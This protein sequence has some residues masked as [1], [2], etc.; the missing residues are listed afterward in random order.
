MNALWDKMKAEFDKQKASIDAVNETVHTTISTTIEAQLLP[1]LQE[2]DKL[3]AEN[4][5]LKSRIKILEAESR[6]N[7]VIIHGVEEKEVNNTELMEIILKTLNNSCKNQNGAEWD[8]WE[9]SRLERLGRK[10]EK[11]VRPIKLTLT[12]EWRKME[13]LR[14]KKSFPKNIKITEDYTKEVLEERKSLIP[15]M[16]EAREAGKY[17]ILKHN[18]LIIKDKIEPKNDKRKRVPSSPPSTPPNN[19]GRADNQEKIDQP[20]KQSK[21]NHLTN[22][23]NS[24]IEAQ[25]KN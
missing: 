20:A 1:I 5:I 22:R 10:I 13:L 21:F 18:K 11:K 16:I 2:T 3:K 25:S 23:S 7:N 6:R 9:I 14:N 17:A 19:F 15:K 4:G 12:L 24:P 8:K